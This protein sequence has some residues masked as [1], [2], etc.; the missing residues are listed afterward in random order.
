MVDEKEREPSLEE[1]QELGVDGTDSNSLDAAMRDAVAAV[2][3]VEKKQASKNGKCRVEDRSGSDSSAGEASTSGRDETEKGGSGGSSLRETER[4]L[5]R[6]RQELA[7]VKDSSLRTLA[8]FDNFRKRSDREKAEARRYA[9]LDPLRDFL[10]VIDNLER[11][12]ASK[13]RLEDLKEGVELILRQMRALLERFSVNAVPALG[14]RFDPTVHEAVMQ[15][16]VE[17]VGEPTVIE[18]FQKGYVLHDRLIR[19]AMVKVAMPATQGE[20]SDSEP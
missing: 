19:P 4:E 2:E 3:A 6:L 10:P 13:G 14:E 16:A 15:E 7:S 12:L 8:D 20:S 1:V 18:E 17:E 9:L 11:A 5:D